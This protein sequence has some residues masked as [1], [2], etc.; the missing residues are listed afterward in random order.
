MQSLCFPMIHDGANS[1]EMLAVLI[2]EPEKNKSWFLHIFSN[3]A[4]F[5]DEKWAQLSS[6]GCWQGWNT[7]SVLGMMNRYIKII[8]YSFPLSLPIVIYFSSLNGSRIQTTQLYL[9]CV[10]HGTLSFCS[11]NQFIIIIITRRSCHS[12][13]SSKSMK[14]LFCFSFSSFVIRYA[15]HVLGCKEVHATDYS[16]ITFANNSMAKF[17]I[18]SRSACSLFLMCMFIY[19]VHQVPQHRPASLCKKLFNT[20]RRHYHNEDNNNDRKARKIWL[21]DMWDIAIALLVES[22]IHSRVCHAQ[23]KI[24]STL[25]KTHSILWHDEND[26]FPLN[27]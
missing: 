5:I 23:S 25:R 8:C 11:F 9:I 19:F 27:Y 7:L 2:N 20:D 15:T 14:I 10:M 21:F 17:C 22:S 12:C 13:S 18:L 16:F 24:K 4:V 26:I 1:S 3:D 6:F